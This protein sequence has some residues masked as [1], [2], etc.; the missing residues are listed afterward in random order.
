MDIV[1]YSLLR[2]LETYETHLFGVDGFHQLVQLVHENFVK[3][4]SKANG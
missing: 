3:G 2:V 4:S 1:V